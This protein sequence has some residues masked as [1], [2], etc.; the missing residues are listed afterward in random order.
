MPA[1]LFSPH[2]LAQL[3]RL[4]ELQLDQQRAQSRSP[5]P[6]RPALFI[7][8]PVADRVPGKQKLAGATHGLGELGTDS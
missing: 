7:S 2:P 1:V 3:K 8:L 4:Y 6:R 5:P